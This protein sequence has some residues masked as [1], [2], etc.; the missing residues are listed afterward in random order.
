MKAEVMLWPL[1]A[2]I[3]GQDVSKDVV[4]G[5]GGYDELKETREFQNA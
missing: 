5:Y 2:K 4:V 3:F 1:A